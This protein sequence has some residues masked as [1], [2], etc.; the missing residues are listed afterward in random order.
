[1][2]VAAGFRRQ[3]GPARLLALVRGGGRILAWDPPT[4]QETR[5]VLERIPPLNWSEVEPLFAQG[6]RFDD[7]PPHPAFARISDPADRKFAA[8]ALAA[9]A[10][11][12]SSDR[13]LLSVRDDL[14]VTV[15]T[16]AEYLTALGPA[17]LE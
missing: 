11:L 14:P 8:L 4:R 6:R 13:H 12:V 3:S 5:Q 7:A 9:G 17:A 10:V 1:V 15:R 16:P 2:F